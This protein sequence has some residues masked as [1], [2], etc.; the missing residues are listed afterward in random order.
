MRVRKKNYFALVLNYGKPLS[1]YRSIHWRCSVRIGVLRNFGKL[2]GKYL[3]QSLFFNKVADLN[4][5]YR[6]P[7]A[8]CF[9]MYWLNVIV[10]LIALSKTFHY[11]PRLA[12][13]FQRS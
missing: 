12:V 7:P 6:S 8:D 2:T 10:A 5:F 9:C 11:A 3:C 1:I 13:C 4:L